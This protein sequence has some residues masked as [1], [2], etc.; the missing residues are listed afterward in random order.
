MFVLLSS[1]SPTP[2]TSFSA[3]SLFFALP[4]SLRS[5]SHISYP[6]LKSYSYLPSDVSLAKRKKEKKKRKKNEARSILAAFKTRHNMV[7]FVISCCSNA[8]RTGVPFFSFP[9][10]VNSSAVAHFEESVRHLFWGVLGAKI[11]SRY[12]RFLLWNVI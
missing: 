6:D 2:H 8:A 11:P 3:F 9:L 5:V 4:F 1:S 10:K 7:A 12:K